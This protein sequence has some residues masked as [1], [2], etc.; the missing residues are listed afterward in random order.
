[1]TIEQI[2]K[3]AIVAAKNNGYGQVVYTDENGKYAFSRDY[4]NNNMHKKENV[5]G[6]VI[7]KWMDGIFSAEYVAHENIK[8]EITSNTTIKDIIHK[9]SYNE[10]DTDQVPVQ[11]FYHVDMSAD[12]LR[13]FISELE[14]SDDNDEID[15]TGDLYAELCLY[16]YSEKD[17]KTELIITDGNNQQEWY[18]VDRQFSNADEL[19]QLI[20]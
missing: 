1:M 14:I 6:K 5:L 4:P 3:N 17:Y 8:Y 10:S 12:E 11:H 9:I 13:S 7:T 18:Y 20:P 15:L 2:I 16:V 19:L